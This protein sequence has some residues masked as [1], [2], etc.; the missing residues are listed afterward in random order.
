M[1]SISVN[2]MSHSSTRIPKLKITEESRKVVWVL[3][4]NIKGKI[5][6]PSSPSRSIQTFTGF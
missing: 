4:Y 1:S 5:S 2:T 3:Y 6:T